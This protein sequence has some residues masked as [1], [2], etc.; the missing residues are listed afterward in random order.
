MNKKLIVLALTASAIT[1]ASAFAADGG[2]LNISGLVSDETC[3][4]RV[5][6]GARDGLISLKTATVSE[7]TT[8]GE[9]SAT[10]VGAK[11]EPFSI[12]VDCSAA[13]ETPAKTNAALTMGSVFFSNSK[14]TLNNDTSIDAPAT[15]T[16]VAIHEVSDTGTYK[17]VLINNPS[18]VHT[19]A[20][21]QNVA[22]YNFTASYVKSDSTTAVG[23]GFVK[24]NAA[25][26]VTYN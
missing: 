4:L 24:T 11:A 25:Y 16:T 26:T 7:V 1:S 19:K 9:V 17:Q 14:G 8:A 6:G 23:G 15:G 2:Q 22:V 18:D 12:T 21:T 10:A 13:G 3:D 20:F 5:N